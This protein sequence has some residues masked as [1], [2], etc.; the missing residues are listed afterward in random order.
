METANTRY[1]KISGSSIVSW[2]PQ[3]Y[4][5]NQAI[6]DCLAQPAH[7]I[8]MEYFDDEGINFDCEELVIHCPLE[9]SHV[10]GFFYDTAV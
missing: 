1:H 10:F 9:S 6:L 7:P 5:F 4:N 2:I 3:L 8:E